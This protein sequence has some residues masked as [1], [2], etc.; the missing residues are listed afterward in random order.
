MRYSSELE[1][2]WEAVHFVI[3]QAI[4]LRRELGASVPAILEKTHLAEL[5]KKL[6]RYIDSAVSAVD[7]NDT[8]LGNAAMKS[9]STASRDKAR[10]LKGTVTQ[11]IV[12]LA[13]EASLGIHDRGNSMTSINISN[14]T[15]ATLNLGSIVGELNSSMQT[16]TNAGQGKLWM[17]CES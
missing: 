3:E 7:T 15:I 10:G 13:L 5:E 2:K 9:I 16:L 4:A 12:E 11:D 1:L 6:H 14:N 17:R 8:T